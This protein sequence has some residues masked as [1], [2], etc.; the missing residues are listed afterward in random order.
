MVRMI[1][2]IK[3]SQKLKPILIKIGIDRKSAKDGITTQ[4]IL[5]DKF[6]IFSISLESI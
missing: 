5:V 4:K 6:F 1:A 3:L 2:I